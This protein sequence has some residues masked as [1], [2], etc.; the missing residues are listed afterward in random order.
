MFAT[1][2]SQ[3]QSDYCVNRSLGYVHTLRLPLRFRCIWLRIQWP[4]PATRN[5]S[6]G[7]YTQVTKECWQTSTR[8]LKQ[9]VPVAPQNGPKPNKNYVFQRGIENLGKWETI[10]SQGILPKYWKN[11]EILTLENGN[12]YWKIWQSEK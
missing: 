3:S 12:K 9:G 11:P 4:G 2:L 8:S 6:G 5:G 7:R 1:S 10:S